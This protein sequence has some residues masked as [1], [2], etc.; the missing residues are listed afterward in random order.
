[1]KLSYLL[2]DLPKAFL[3]TTITHEVTLTQSDQLKSFL[4]GNSAKYNAYL[5]DVTLAFKHRRKQLKV[6][7]ADAT[8]ALTR[9][10]GKLL[11]IRF[12]IRRHP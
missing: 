4:L 7:S 5:R 2:P 11:K 3:S 1:M 12:K 8:D 9:L 10:R 6:H